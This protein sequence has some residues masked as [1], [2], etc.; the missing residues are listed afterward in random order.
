[1]ALFSFDPAIMKPIA[2][3]LNLVVAGTSFWYFKKNNHFRWNLF[4]PFAITSVPAAYFGG[5]LILDPTLYKQILGG[6]MFLA[7]LRLFLIKPK[8]KEDKKEVNLVLAIVM[9]AL[10]GF[11]SGMIGIGGGIILSPLI[12]LLN[13]GSAKETAAA[14]AL[15]IF[16]NSAA[17]ILGLMNQ[18]QSIPSEITYIIP[19]AL[20]GAIGGSLLG[21][22]KLKNLHVQ[23][24]LAAVLLVAGIK[25]FFV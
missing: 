25:L 24:L 21:S 22:K 23:Y 19:A 16:V 5:R 4:F 18:G 13:W 17:G 6:F 20:L 2:L 15:F 10:I 11:F 1:M 14:S 9:G 12:L 7:V 8:E 3:T